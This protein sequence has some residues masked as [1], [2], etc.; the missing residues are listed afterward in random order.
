VWHFHLH[1][2]GG[3]E[4]LDA[5]VEERIGSPRGEVTLIHPGHHSELQF[6]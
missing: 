6:L 2:E 3:L 4:R 5:R 1:A